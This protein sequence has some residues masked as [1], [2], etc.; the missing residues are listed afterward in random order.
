M[1]S[2]LKIEAAD[3]DI[4][5]KVILPSLS[6]VVTL[7]IVYALKP[8]EK[9]KYKF[10]SFDRSKDMR[11]E[12]RN[13]LE[14][15]SNADSRDKKLEELKNYIR[16]CEEI[17]LVINAK[18]FDKAI[19]SSIIEDFTPIFK[20]ESFKNI[21]EMVNHGDFPEHEKIKYQR[22]I[23]CYGGFWFKRAFFRFVWT[24]EDAFQLRTIYSKI[25]NFA[26]FWKKH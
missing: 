13:V 6:T 15:I 1:F 18:L 2:F 25:A 5:Y 21:W 10:E 22:I 16:C 14:N 4:I 12:Y 20:H 24:L 26:K 8:N 3:I 7:M 9:I 19:L 23:E 17:A 11:T